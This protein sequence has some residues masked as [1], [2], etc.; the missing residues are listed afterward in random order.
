[1]TRE[2][3]GEVTPG[4]VTRAG[5]SP[6]MWLVGP[7]QQSGNAVSAQHRVHPDIGITQLADQLGDLA[8]QHVAR[9]FEGLAEP[10]LHGQG[11]GVGARIGIEVAQQRLVGT[12]TRRRGVRHAPVAQVRS[13]RVAL[14]GKRGGQPLHPVDGRAFPG[15]S[16]QDGGPPGHP[17]VLVVRTEQGEALAPQGQGTGQRPRP[18]VMDRPHLAL[19]HVQQPQPAQRVR[20]PP[21]RGRSAG[22]RSSAP[23][24]GSIGRR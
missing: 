3:S 7:Q 23:P 6:P 8:L 22:A 4:G 12:H 15:Q 19:A 2:G 16:G 21:A 17:A 5:P 14:V 11:D 10:H 24:P 9:R 13:Q 18:H 20:P 1:M